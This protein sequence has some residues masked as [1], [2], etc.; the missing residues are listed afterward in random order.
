MVR[1]LS[2]KSLPFDPE[3][4]QVIY[5]E[6]S[7]HKKL[8]TF[9]LDH[10]TWL[11]KTFHR[12]GLEFC[13]LPNLFDET[14]HYHAPYLKDEECRAIIDGLPSLTD[15]AIDG[16]TIE[17]SFVFALDIPVENAEG[18]TVLQSVAIEPKWYRPNKRT[19]AL[20]AKEVK[21][22]AVERSIYYHELR[23]PEKKV[24]TTRAAT[25]GSASVML[26]SVSFHVVVNW[27]TTPT[28]ISIVSHVN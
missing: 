6:S 19:F 18:N 22:V 25:S 15:Y 1:E 16:E 26:M 10:Y 20:L 21:R 2:F 3:S 12:H 13:Y 28:I 7:Y 14:V 4:G 23:K 27:Q 24:R 8:N 17:P 5:V 11:R 9:I